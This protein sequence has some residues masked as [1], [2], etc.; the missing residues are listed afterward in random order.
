M[1]T[2]NVAPLEKLVHSEKNSLLL[3]LGSQELESINPKQEQT[4][5]LLMLMQDSKDKIKDYL[6]NSTHLLT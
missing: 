4:S 2:E 6:L 5:K 1:V 3:K